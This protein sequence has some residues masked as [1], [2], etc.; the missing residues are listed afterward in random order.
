MT[1]L[2]RTILALCL[3]AAPALAEEEEATP[4]DHVTEADRLWQNFNRETAVVG[5]G[6]LRLAARVSIINKAVDDDEPDL[7]GYPFIDLLQQIDIANGDVDGCPPGGNQRQTCAKVESIEGIRV[8]VMGAYGLG[9]NVEVGFDMPFFSE[10]LKF[11]GDSEPTWNTEDVGDLVLYGKFRKSLSNS[12]S[13]GAGLEMSVPT[14]RES[15]RLGT[16]ELGF[17]PFTNIRYTR[18]RLALGGHIGFYMSDGDVADV[19]NYS[20]FAI[21][22]ASENLAFRIELNGRFFRDFGTDFNDVSLWPGFDFRLGDTVV[23]RPQGNVGLTGDAWDWGLGAAI[24][25][26]PL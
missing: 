5:S 11:V 22:R 4:A 13:M 3:L 15:K 16:G 2:G 9:S 20:T 1:F 14:G 24:V 8:D 12:V 23:V 25:W 26:T 18:G 19:L 7:T 6:T 21:A 10:S 17:N